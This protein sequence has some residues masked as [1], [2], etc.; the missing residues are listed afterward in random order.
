MK[1]LKFFQ[2]GSVIVPVSI[3]IIAKLFLISR[4]EKW[5][6]FFYA[7]M[8][9][10]A[11]SFCC[12]ACWGDDRG[13]FILELLDLERKLAKAESREFDYGKWLEKHGM[14]PGDITFRWF[15]SKEY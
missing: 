12:A 15:D 7:A 2:L 11:W 3:I 1:L 9:G 5:E 14:K 10:W 13:K 6:I 4:F 8:G